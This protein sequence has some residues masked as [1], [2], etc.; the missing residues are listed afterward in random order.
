MVYKLEERS[1][2]VLQ[3]IRRTGRQQQKTE[4]A[5]LLCQ[6]VIDFCRH[7]RIESESKRVNRVESCSLN[8]IRLAES[9]IQKWRFESES[10]R[11]NRVESSNSNS[12]RL[13]ESGQSVN[14]T[15]FTFLSA[16]KSKSCCTYELP[17]NLGRLSC[18]RW[19]LE[20][21]SMASNRIGEP[22]LNPTDCI[23]K[24]CSRLDKP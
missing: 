19:R 22:N 8:S 24:V 11:V 21:G 14:R 7:H 6:I 12:I 13:A 18:Q 23:L 2:E 4:Q 15:P 10:N 20:I 1:A 16:Y 17:R 5:L 3:S 9:G